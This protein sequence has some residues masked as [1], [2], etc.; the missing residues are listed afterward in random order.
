[1][2]AGAAGTAAPTPTLTAPED[3]MR[4]ITHLEYLVEPYGRSWT[5]SFHGL[6]QGRYPH[7]RSALRAAVRDARHLQEKGCGIRVLV[8][9]WNGRFRAVPDHLLAPIAAGAPP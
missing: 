1:M 5:Y 6:R 7:R 9:R 4:P 8:R 2:P 3:A